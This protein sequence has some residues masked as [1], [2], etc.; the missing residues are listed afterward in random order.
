M[1]QDKAMEWQLG[2]MDAD[3]DAWNASKMKE[4]E[5]LMGLFSEDG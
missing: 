1:E 3:Q 4:I 2:A 5:G